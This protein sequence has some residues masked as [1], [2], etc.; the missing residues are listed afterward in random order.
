MAEVK[1]LRLVKIA[2]ELNVGTHTIIEHLKGAGYEVEDKPTAKL[3]A[4]MYN[5]LL[6]EFQKDAAVKEKAEKITIGAVDH[7]DVVLTSKITPPKKEAET[8]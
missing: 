2:N 7:K 1:S 4:E 8:D 5:L 6:K 3:T